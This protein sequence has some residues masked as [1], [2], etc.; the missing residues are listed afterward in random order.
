MA[1]EQ[2]FHIWE[3]VYRE[4][5]EAPLVGDAFNDAKWLADQAA[6]TG[7]EIAGLAED[8]IAAC[9]ISRDYVLPLVAA[10]T[11]QDGR[12]PRIL[13]FGGGMAS[14]YPLV[15]G[16]VPG[17]EAIEFHV[18]ESCGIC[19]RAQAEFAG[20]NNLFFH[21]ELPPVGMDFDIV[22]AGRSMQYVDDWCG[23]LRAFADRN[24]QY[25]VLAGLLAGDIKPFVTTQNY[26]GCK[27]PVRFL[28]RDEL[29]R[30][31]E[32]LGYCLVYKSLHFSKRLGKEGS[33][34]MDNF[35]PENRLE[36]PCQLLFRRGAR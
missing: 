12:A 33:L 21:T 27:I 31:V 30:A 22:H 14:S 28:N 1:A 29:I 10:L 6:H 25:I 2:I 8:G 16:A 19:Q 32:D 3:G 23:L 34:P 4:W 13:D 7:A 36:H 17:S 11:M 18:L 9:A 24:A 35:P 15:M 20:H 26:Y 5:G